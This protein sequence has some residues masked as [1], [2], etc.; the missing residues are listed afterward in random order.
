MIAAL[1]FFWLFG[2]FLGK[3]KSNEKKPD[4]KK[5]AEKKPPEEKK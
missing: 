5:S 4:E 2:T 1:P 3:K